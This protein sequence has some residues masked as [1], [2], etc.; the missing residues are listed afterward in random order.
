ML[1]PEQIDQIADSVDLINS[2]MLLVFDKVTNTHMTALRLQELLRAPLNNCK[3]LE[4]FV[5]DLVNAPKSRKMPDEINGEPL[6]V[7]A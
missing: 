3:N 4:S 5:D 6:G 7:G 1:T 2:Q